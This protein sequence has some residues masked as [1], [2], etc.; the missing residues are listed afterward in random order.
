MSQTELEPIDMSPPLSQLLDENKQAI[1]LDSWVQFCYAT[2]LNL[3]QPTLTVLE[4]RGLLKQDKLRDMKLKPP[5]DESIGDLTLRQKPSIDEFNRIVR[6]IRA[7]LQSVE[8]KIYWDRAS[9][10][11]FQRASKALSLQLASEPIDEGY[12]CVICRDL[13]L[14]EKIPIVFHFQDPLF[15]R[16][17]PYVLCQRHSYLIIAYVALNRLM[18]NVHTMLLGPEL[19]PVDLDEPFLVRFEVYKLEEQ[20]DRVNQMLKYI[21]RC[22]SKES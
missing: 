9:K 21:H 22:I 10:E 15:I 12:E 5:R 11:L 1:S 14:K 20:L 18:A 19:V 16:S 3:R 7:Y 2:W 17:T 4:S 6:M 13:E 8:K